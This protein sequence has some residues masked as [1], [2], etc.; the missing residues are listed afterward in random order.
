MRRAADD[1]GAAAASATSAPG[2]IAEASFE[3]EPLEPGTGPVDR[4]R[5]STASAT[6]PRPRCAPRSTRRA[7]SWLAL[8]GHDHDGVPHQPIDEDRAHQ[9]HLHRPPLRAG[10]T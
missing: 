7:W 5:S 10:A 1:L 4:R 2:E 3:V 9:G 8:Y 6:T